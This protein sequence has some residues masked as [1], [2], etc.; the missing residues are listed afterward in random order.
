MLVLVHRRGIHRPAEVR[1]PQLFSSLSCSVPGCTPTLTIE[2]LVGAD[3][4]HV[5]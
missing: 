1:S 2:S 5:Q 4:G 3:T